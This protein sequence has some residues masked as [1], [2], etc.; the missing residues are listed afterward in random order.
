M[1]IE[2]DAVAFGKTLPR[3]TRL[4]IPFSFQ[5]AGSPV[6]LQAGGYT[7]NV[8]VLDV[9]GTTIA[10][11]FACAISGTTAT[12]AMRATDLDIASPTTGDVVEFVC[13]ATDGAT[14]LVSDR[15]TIK[16]GDWGGADLL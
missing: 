4:S 8:Y 1:A 11:P 16:V 9:D 14:V 5:V 10:G 7:A 13:H 6:D 12:Y 2:S 15:R 3:H